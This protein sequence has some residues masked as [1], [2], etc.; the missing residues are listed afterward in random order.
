[1]KT[2]GNPDRAREFILRIASM[3]VLDERPTK[4]II[5]DAWVLTKPQIHP[6]SPRKTD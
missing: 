6:P 5:E 4:E 1:M 3:P 2:K